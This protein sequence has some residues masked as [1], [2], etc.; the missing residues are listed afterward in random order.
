MGCFCTCV[1]HLALSLCTVAAYNEQ[2]FTDPTVLGL[3]FFLFT[4]VLTDWIFITKASK[5]IDINYIQF[6]Q[7]SELTENSDSKHTYNSKQWAVAV[8]WEY[9]DNSI[10]YSITSM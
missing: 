8:I 6:H 10:F 3:V 1:F 9:I 4:Y 7:I 2:S 5:H